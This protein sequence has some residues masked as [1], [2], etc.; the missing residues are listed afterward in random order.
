MRL[1]RRVFT[2]HEDTRGRDYVTKNVTDACDYVAKTV[3]D[4]TRS[5]ITG[6]Q[7]I[8]VRDFVQM[9]RVVRRMDKYSFTLGVLGI[10]ATQYVMLQKTD[11]FKYYYCVVMFPLLALRVYLYRQYKWHYFVID[12]CYFV[13]ALGFLLVLTPL[14]RH[15]SAWQ[16]LFVTS[17]GPVMFAIVAWRNSLVFH[18]LD[19]VTSVYIHLFPAL[20]SWCERWHGCP[21]A[22]ESLSGFFSGAWLCCP[23][24]YY[25]LWQTLYL[26]Q[27]EVMDKNK[28]DQDPS[29]KTSF[30]WL[31]IDTRSGLH[32]AVKSVCRKL[33]I[34]HG[35]EGFQVDSLKTKLVFVATQLG[36]TLMCYLP[37]YL[38]H[39]FKFAN[40]GAIGLI[41][42][43]AVWNGGEGFT[44]TQTQ[45]Q[46]Q[47]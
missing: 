24:A 45:T 42:S 38:L 35:Q 44:L 15:P 39:S 13:N 46:T 20:L 31:V 43:M 33:G 32:I 28:L 30:R 21:E 23:L 18:S 11:L 5:T 37:C 6:R 10:S 3:T 27:T 36:Y 8:R 12:F 22:Q 16:T 17:T 25:V 41:F 26:L 9:P 14:A 2:G 7:D 34:L 19:K 4:A 29:I 40:T 47:T 1:T